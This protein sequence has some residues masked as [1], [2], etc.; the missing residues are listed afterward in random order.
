MT[1]TTT[2]N[3]YFYA[4]TR[5]PPSSSRLVHVFDVD[6]TL[7]LKPETFVNIGLTSEQYFDA[8]RTFDLDQQVAG[9]LQTL[10][11]LGDCIA[12]A[13]SRPV[14]RLRQTYEWLQRHNVPFDVLMASTGRD[15]SSSTKQRMFHML[16]DQYAGI[17]TFVDDSPYNIAAGRL[18]GINC[19][20]VPKNEEYWAAHPEEVVLIKAQ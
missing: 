6:D 13:T 17:S 3:P 11:D 4:I 14:Q 1:T 7:T 19:I 20:H 2:K 5:V 12:I 8:A 9:L 16:T 15:I 18:H 10:H